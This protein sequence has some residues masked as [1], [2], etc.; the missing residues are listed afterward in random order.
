MIPECHGNYR[1]KG[2]LIHLGLMGPPDGDPGC[3]GLNRRYIVMGKKQPGSESKIMEKETEVVN[4]A[5][6]MGYSE[7]DIIETVKKILSSKS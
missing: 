1:M 4:E 5:L 7:N 2:I 6:A 3:R